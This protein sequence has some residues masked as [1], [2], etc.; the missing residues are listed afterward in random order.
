MLVAGSWSEMLTND[1][2]A[3][4]LIYTCNY[5][6][7]EWIG[8]WTNYGHG[9]GVGGMNRKAIVVQWVAGQVQ[10]DLDLLGKAFQSG[11]LRWVIGMTRGNV[12]EWFHWYSVKVVE[13]N[14]VSERE[15]VYVPRSGYMWSNCRSCP[16]IGSGSMQGVHMTSVGWFTGCGICRMTLQIVPGDFLHNWWCIC[17]L[18]NRYL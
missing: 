15:W 18:L 9:V 16:S 12:W 7:D 14:R 2:R 5:E 13:Y 10:G 1:D 4:L 3:L 11:K 17:R 6:V 8:M